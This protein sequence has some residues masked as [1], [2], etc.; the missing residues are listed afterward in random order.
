MYESCTR[1]KLLPLT[2]SAP[3]SGMSFSMLRCILDSSSNPSLRP[4]NFRCL[5]CHQ[6]SSLPRRFTTTTRLRSK[7]GT[8][9]DKGPFRSRLRTAL[10]NTK[11]E[12][13]PIPLGLGFAFLGAVQFYRVWERERKKQRQEEE[14]DLRSD[15]SGGESHSRPKKRKRIRPSGPW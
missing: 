6:K 13:A 9:Q 5:F 3:V 8:N 15:E 10:R 12:W 1:P 14:D 7:D 2:S 11:I 4:A